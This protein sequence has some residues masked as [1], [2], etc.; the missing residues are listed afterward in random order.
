MGMPK[1]SQ[2]DNK[3]GGLHQLYE[4]SHFSYT[5]LI[6]RLESRGK[7]LVREK[8]GNKMSGFHYQSGQGQVKHYQAANHTV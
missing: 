3:K 5:G 8:S 2:I 6:V 7:K 1:I 4:R